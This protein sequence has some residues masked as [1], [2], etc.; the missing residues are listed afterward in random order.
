MV[1]WDDSKKFCE[2][3]SELDGKR[4]YS[5]PTEEQW[6]YACRAGTIGPT[7]GPLDRIAWYHNNSNRQSQ[8]VGQLAPNAWGLY[9]GI[10]NVW[11]WCG[12]SNDLTIRCRGGSWGDC[13][14]IALRAA[15]RRNWQER[16]NAVGFRVLFVPEP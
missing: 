12:D 15:F 1:T 4:T 11:E 16:H 10:G 9:D 13:K 3:L 14:G 6:E 2:K 7:Y 8:P 5:I